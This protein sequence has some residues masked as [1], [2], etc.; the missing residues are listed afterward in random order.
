MQSITEQHD[1]API[2]SRHAVLR[3]AHR[4]VSPEHED[5]ARD[6]GA[7]I[8]QPGGRRVWHLGRKE[9][10]RARRSGGTVPE[11]AV[12]V[13]VVESSGGVVITVLRSHDRRRLQRFRRR[14]S[15]PRAVA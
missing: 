9:A 5:F 8:R 1:F 4:H 10:A 14:R 11:A 15:N 6:W 12:G 7:L 2:S 13:A 3:R